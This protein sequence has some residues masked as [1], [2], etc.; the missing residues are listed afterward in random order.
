MCLNF[1]AAIVL[2]VGLASSALIYHSAAG[3]SDSIFGYEDEGGTAYPVNPDDSKQYLRGLELYGGTA[4]VL[5]DDLRRWFE[6]LWH[7][8]SLA[9]TV[10]F[11]TI[12]ISAGF[13][14]AA[15]HSPPRPRSGH[16]GKDSSGRN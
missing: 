1:I 4:N 3:N 10:A 13:F 15:R 2:G 8:E 9:F 14:Y 7:G 16:P 12:I 11:L 6:G 5:A